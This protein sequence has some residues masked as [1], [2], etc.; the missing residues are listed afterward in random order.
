MGQKGEFELHLNNFIMTKSQPLIN[1]EKVKNSNGRRNR[2]RQME[3]FD[4]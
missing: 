4:N 1:I 3:L 2:R